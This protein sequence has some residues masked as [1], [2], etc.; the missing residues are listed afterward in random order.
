MKRFAEGQTHPGNFPLVT[1]RNNEGQQLMTSPVIT[2]KSDT[3]VYEIARLLTTHCINNVPVINEEDQV[4]G[5]V[6]KDDLFLKQRRLRLKHI[7]VI[8]GEIPE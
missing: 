8:H 6:S 3:T 7:Q 5:V 4:I 1:G 2:V